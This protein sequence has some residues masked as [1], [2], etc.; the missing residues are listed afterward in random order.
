MRF[1][2]NGILWQIIFVPPNSSYLIDRTGQHTVATTD[3]LTQ[4]I[5]LSSDL[6]GDFKTRVI[7]HEI[8]HCALFSFNLLSAIHS[9]VPPSE[10]V[11]AEEWVCN[12]FADYG[13]YIFNALYDVI[14]E[15]IWQYIPYRIH[16]LIA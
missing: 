16:D 7:I 2:L 6:T 12:L 10:W 8:G 4:C 11:I 1:R 9:L 14:G 15:E 13:L 5:Y 3:P